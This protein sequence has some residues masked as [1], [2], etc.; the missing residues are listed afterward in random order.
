MLEAA[1]TPSS[2]PVRT[3]SGSPDLDPLPEDSP[4]PEAQPPSPPVTATPPAV[5]RSSRSTAGQTT[6]Y[7]D[8][9]AAICEL[10]RTLC[11]IELLQQR[12]PEVPV[13]G[14]GR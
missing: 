3:D 13:G 7:K 6:H 12:Y 5:R 8:Y 14:G 2:D 9:V 4:L 10:A 1:S 11:K